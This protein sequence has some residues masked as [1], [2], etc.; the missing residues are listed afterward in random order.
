M[1]GQFTQTAFAFRLDFKQVEAVRVL[2]SDSFD[3]PNAGVGG[4]GRADLALGGRGEHTYLPLCP[5]PS[6]PIGARL[7]NG[8]LA[9]TGRDFGGVQFADNVFQ[10]FNLRVQL[11]VPRDSAGTLPRPAPI[12]QPRGESRRRDHRR[13]VGRLLG[14]TL[15]H[16][17]VKV[18][19]LNPWTEVAT[20]GAPAR[21]T[22]HRPTRWR[23]TCKAAIWQS[24]W[25]ATCSCFNRTAGWGWPVI[26]VSVGRATCHG[27]QPRPTRS[28]L[29]G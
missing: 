25:M 26:G 23:S 3:R 5:G 17:E 15:E 21:S 1:E 14:P 2:F 22:V 18:K 10:D 29:R 16:G 28:A 19:C 13:H 27:L 24:L 20:S 8:A 11:R 12:S 9:N 7:A 6:G 4:L